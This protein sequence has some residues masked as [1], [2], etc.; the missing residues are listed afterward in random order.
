MKQSTN[1]DDERTRENRENQNGQSAPL[2]LYADEPRG[3]YTKLPLEISS[4]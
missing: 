4:V 2:I 3:Y 1:G